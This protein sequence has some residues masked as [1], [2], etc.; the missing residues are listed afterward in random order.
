MHLLKS[1]LIN[2]FIRTFQPRAGSRIYDNFPRPPLDGFAADEKMPAGAGLTPPKTR[3]FCFLTELFQNR[4]SSS[5]GMP[6]SM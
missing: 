2:I 1:V 4:T 5:P 6:R 3:L